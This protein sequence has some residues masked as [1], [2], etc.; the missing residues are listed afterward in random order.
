[1]PFRVQRGALMVDLRV[2]PNGGSDRVEGLSS[3][4]S[5]RFFLRARVSASPEKGKANAA[6]LKLLARSWGLARSRL[7]LVAGETDRNKV[8]CIS[9]DVAELLP[10]LQRWLTRHMNSI[11]DSSK[12]EIGR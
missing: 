2:T 7:E 4:A 12:A 9:G 5:G 8:V 11:Q 10:Q 6:V 1:M 3:D